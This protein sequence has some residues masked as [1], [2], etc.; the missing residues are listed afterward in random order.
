MSCVS[1]PCPCCPTLYRLYIPRP[2]PRATAKVRYL[3]SNLSPPLDQLFYHCLYIFSLSLLYYAFT[4]HP[5]RR[6]P[7]SYTTSSNAVLAYSSSFISDHTSFLLSP[8]PSSASSCTLAI[9]LVF[10]ILMVEDRRSG[11]KPGQAQVFPL[12]ICNTSSTGMLLSCGGLC[13]PK[14]SKCISKWFTSVNSN[15]QGSKELNNFGGYGARKAFIRR[16]IAY[17]PPVWKW[18]LL[19]HLSSSHH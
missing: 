6:R 7:A 15:A 14:P 10:T 19:Y 8:Y 18:P 17:T 5:P 2:V 4:P 11:S 13:H 9:Q 1:C 16:G 3:S 12:L